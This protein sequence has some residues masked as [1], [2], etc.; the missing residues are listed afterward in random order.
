[1]EILESF[2]NAAPFISELVTVDI[3]IAVT[4]REKYLSYCPGDELNH[5]VQTGQELKPGSLVV[6][7]MEE[8]RKITERVDDKSLFGCRYI[9]IAIPLKDSAGNVVGSVFA[10]ENTER[11]DLINEISNHLTA[12]SSD[13]KEATQDIAE[14]AQDLSSSVN[15]LN[16]YAE[17][18]TAE[19]DEIEKVI[20]FVREIA[21]QTNLLGLN[22]AIEAARVGK[23]GRGFGVV[24]DEIRK[25][26]KESDQS[27]EQITEI[28]N[29]IEDLSYKIKGVTE[30]VQEIADNQAA[31]ME[32]T[33]ASSDELN[34]V[35]SKLEDLA[36]NFNKGEE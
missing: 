10:G 30:Q 14:Q 12:S 35:A 25:L 22:A 11:Q 21:S 33:A 34:E 7:A 2:I 29:S 8:S 31:V 24:A 9:G 36:G 3:A 16:Q 1:M 4:D 28:L 27:L 17:R 23:A 26:S 32:E 15:K 5:G 19:M 20:G 6:R 13:L 18:S